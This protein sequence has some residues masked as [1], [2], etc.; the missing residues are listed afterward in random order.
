MSYLEK[1]IVKQFNPGDVIFKEGEPG[2]SM[3]IIQ[4]GD[5]E[6]HKSVNGQKVVL[7]TL[8][9]GSIFGEMSLI[10]GRPRSATVQA[11]TACQCLE[12]NQILFKQRLGE[13][14]G[15]MKSFFLILVDRL[16][17]ADKS[18][19]ADNE[20]TTGRRIVYLLNY[21]MD[22]VESDQDN[23]KI[24]AWSETVELIAMLMNIPEGKINK[25]LNRLALT[26]LGKSEINYEKGKLLIIEKPELFARYAD[27]CKEQ[28]EK[29]TGTPLQ[30][31]FDATPKE[32]MAVLNFI[33]ALLKQQ[34]SANDFPMA[35]FN[36]QFEEIVGKPVTD[37]DFVL[38]KFRKHGLLKIKL[39]GDSE[40]Y[41]EVDRD[42]FNNRL[43]AG[44]EVELFK[45]LEKRLSVI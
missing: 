25:L 17:S 18:Q 33:Q 7:A 27:Y 31:E 26:E 11:K 9:D 19:A 10:D 1:Q 32:E 45:K 41:Y 35:Y 3:F 8:K 40:K 23:R 36:E 21:L 34:A 38:K 28:F 2:T 30:T 16:R 37:F 13:V 22:H 39:E 44:S 15:W 29:E 12:V 6:V 42:L 43:N 4:K 5:V 20:K 14:P 24:L